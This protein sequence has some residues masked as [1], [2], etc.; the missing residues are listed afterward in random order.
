MPRAKKGVREPPSLPLFSLFLSLRVLC[1]VHVVLPT[2]SRIAISLIL[3]HHTVY[4]ET[5]GIRLLSLIF[6]LS[7]SLVPLFGRCF[8]ITCASFFSLHS[9]GI[10]S[11]CCRC[12]FGTC[13][14]D[15]IVSSEERRSRL[16]KPVPCLLPKLNKARRQLAFS[17]SSSTS[18][19]RSAVIG[20]NKTEKCLELTASSQTNRTQRDV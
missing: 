9:R 14:S 7:I 16:M 1:L 17:V 18:S 6:A 8:A 13:K 15:A 10:F 2:R 20:P 19:S 12:A 3:T 11:F 4:I 5:I